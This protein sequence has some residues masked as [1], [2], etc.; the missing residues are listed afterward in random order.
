MGPE[1]KLYQKLKRVSRGIIWNRIENL[2]LLGMPDLLGYNSSG[3]FFTVELKVTR[4]NKLKFSPHQIA[5]H[6][7]H[8]KNSFIIAEARGPR[9]SKLIQM[10]SG[11][12]IR[13]LAACGLKLEALCVGLEASC[14][15]LSKLGA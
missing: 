7:Q 10:F 9:S 3:H 1:A 15:K 4:G 14:L 11:S 2:S 5:W 6:V 12:R 8:P 13:E